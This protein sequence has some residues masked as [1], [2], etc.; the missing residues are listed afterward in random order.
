[1]SLFLFSFACTIVASKG[2]GRKVV[3]EAGP[4]RAWEV[5]YSNYEYEEASI[6]DKI[7]NEFICLGAPD[8]ELFFPISTAHTLYDTKHNKIIT[9]MSLDR[10]IIEKLYNERLSKK[11]V[12]PS[13]IMFAG[14]M[15]YLDN[16][17]YKGFDFMGTS[18]IKI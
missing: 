13:E 7:I 1:M 3:S 17:K 4:G 18:F 6:K 11:G 9:V 14:S 15:E 8:E 2:N 12:R 16:K 5:D 10:S